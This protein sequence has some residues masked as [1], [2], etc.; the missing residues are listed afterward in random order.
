MRCA[1]DREPTIRMYVQFDRPECVKNEIVPA[2]ILLFRSISRKNVETPKLSSTRGGRVAV[3]FSLRS[4]TRL[5]SYILYSSSI[6][7]RVRVRGKRMLFP[8]FD[9]SFQVMFLREIETHGIRRRRILKEKCT[10]NVNKET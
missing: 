8:F 3:D 6:D 1:D 10:M 7:V 9:L 2:A 5:L 4:T